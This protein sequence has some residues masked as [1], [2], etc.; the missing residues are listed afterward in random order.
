MFYLET[1]GGGEGRD[2]KREEGG[3]ER[4]GWEEGEQKRIKEKVKEWEALVPGK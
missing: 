2:R 1:E 3:R 4:E